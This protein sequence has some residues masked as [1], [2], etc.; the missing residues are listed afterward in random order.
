QKS[1]AL[2]QSLDWFGKLQYR[3]CR[4]S[5]N[6]P[7]IKPP[8]QMERLLEEMHLVPPAGTPVFAGFKAF[9]YIAWRIPVF[10]LLAPLLYLPGIPWLGNK[11]YLWIA[12][13]RYKLVP[14]KDGVCNIHP[15]KPIA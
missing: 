8:L 9:R 15:R 12:R 7:A 10:W 4:D 3:D 6:L 2:L 5:E 14:C 11:M 1:V 13:N